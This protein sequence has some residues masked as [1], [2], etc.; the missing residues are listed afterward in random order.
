[1]SYGKIWRLAKAPLALLQQ[2]QPSATGRPSRELARRRHRRRLA[3]RGESP[4]RPA[5]RDRPALPPPSAGRCSATSQRQVV[6]A[7]ESRAHGARSLPGRRARG[8]A[9]AGGA[10]CRLGHPGQ[11][12]TLV[13]SLQLQ[14]PN[15]RH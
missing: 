12:R 11:P 4:A 13:P 5:R 2:I 10:V 1:V 6:H 8:G 15:S 9:R 7:V 14:A 3:G